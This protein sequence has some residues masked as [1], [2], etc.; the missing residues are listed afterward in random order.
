MKYIILVGDG[1]ADHPH[2]ELNHKTPLQA[3][4]TPN[5]DFLAS[6][7]RFGLAR[8]LLDG[9]P[10]GSD[11]ANLAVMGY[12]PRQYYSGR[13]PL[14]A[15]NIGVDLG[16]KDVAFRC[17]LVSVKN[18]TM[19][20]FSSGHISTE[21][22]KPLI[23]MLGQKLGD[24]KIKFYLGTS[25]RHLVVW[26]SGPIKARCV[27]PHD[28][29]GKDISAYLPQGPGHKPL[30]QLME[31]SRFLLE[32]HEVNRARR[33]DGHAPA[34]MIWLWGQGLKPQMPTLTEKYHLTGSVISAVDL[35]K[36]IGLYAGLNVEK[37]P[38]VTGYLDTNYVGKAEA[39]LRVLKKHDFVF[40]H[41][42]APDEC[43][44]NGDLAGKIR[45]IEDFDEKVVGVVLKGLEGMSDFK[46]M[47]LPDHPTPLDVKTHT[48]EAV[49]FLIYQPGGPASGADGYY[50]EAACASGLHIN[51]AWKL[52]DIFITGQWP[53]TASENTDSQTEKPNQ[54]PNAG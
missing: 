39:A 6:H 54:E 9:Y 35:I 1:M 5:M 36:G 42:E 16:P 41:V 18:N 27:P 46:I 48:N 33:Q 3:A 21:E 12:D 30:V 11:V 14:E 34:N 40:V 25:Y 53:E 19:F 2:P 44:H 51:E 43:G 28:I 24:S 13:A 49:P 29:T 8:T 15:A 32:G 7:G 22:A 47:I 37:V 45:A 31:D 38:G 10:L 23:K 26:Q 17:N 50:E 4:K 52:M 20:D